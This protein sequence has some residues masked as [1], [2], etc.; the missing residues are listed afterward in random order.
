MPSGIRIVAPCGMLGY[1]FPLESFQRAFEKK[2]D[3]IVVDAGSTDAGPH[4]L[5]GNLSIV[6]DVALKRDLEIIIEEG[7]PRKVPIIIGSAGGTGSDE[8]VE[9]TYE[10]IRQ[11]LQ[12]KDYSAKI[13]LIS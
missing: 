12:E 10:I 7:L 5:G 3:A 1:G 9:K 8:H 2:V 13:G 11:L 6:S 4:K